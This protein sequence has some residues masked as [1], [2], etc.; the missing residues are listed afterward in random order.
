MTFL[1]NKINSITDFFLQNDANNYS[2]AHTFKWISK[3]D[4]NKIRL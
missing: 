3:K 4:C 1:K 2:Q